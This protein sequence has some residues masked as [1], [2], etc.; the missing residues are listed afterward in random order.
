M[1]WP[2][3]PG[4][5]L[6]AATLLAAL[7]ALAAAGFIARIDGVRHAVADQ[8]KLLRARL[9][10]ESLVQ[11]AIVKIDSGAQIPLDGKRARVSLGED[12]QQVR[13][14]NATGLIDL[15]TAEPPQLTALLVTLGA[16]QPYAETIAD[17]IADWRDED[18]L[19]RPSGAER[20]AYLA[21]RLPEP[22]NAKFEVEEE[23]LAVLGVREDLARCLEPYVTVFSGRSDVNA[24]YAP[25]RVR[26]AL[27]LTAPPAVADQGIPFGQVLI[28][29][30]ETPLSSG[31]ALRLTQWTR[32]TGD[33]SRPYMAHRSR[34][35]FTALDQD[36]DTACR[37]AF[38][39]GAL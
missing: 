36:A 22:R 3:R 15:N 5:A 7:L 6:L 28:I 4:S 29:R 14:Q 16:S 12:A 34:L 27:K 17:R 33:Q 2:A 11:A 31:A 32:L 25:D 23:L 19:R 21:R 10:V 39:A 38:A 37:R 24:A 18:S 9:E 8:Q 1:R 26:Q 30:A 20:S 13:V 35:D